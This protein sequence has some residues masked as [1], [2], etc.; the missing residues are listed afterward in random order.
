MRRPGFLAIV[1]RELLSASRRRQTYWGRSQAAAIALVPTGLILF[2]Q[3]LSA[4]GPATLGVQLFRTLAFVSLGYAM[5][6]AV[7][8]AAEAAAGGRVVP[9]RSG[10]RHWPVIPRPARLPP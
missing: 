5:L 7:G 1:T 2:S 3:T 9:S 8:P 4:V 10:A 6:A